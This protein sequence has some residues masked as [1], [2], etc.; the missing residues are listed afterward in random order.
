[1][2]LVQ[3]RRDEVALHAHYG[4][5]ANIAVSRCDARFGRQVPDSGFDQALLQ[6][7]SRSQAKATI[8]RRS[9]RRAIALGRLEITMIPSATSTSRCNRRV[10]FDC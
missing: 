7:A 6:Y 3:D 1:M 5:I 2:T 4:L 10:L 8:S 9:M